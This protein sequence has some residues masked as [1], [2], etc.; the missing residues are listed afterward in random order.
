MRPRRARRSGT[1]DRYVIGSFLLPFVVSLLFF[2]LLIEMADLFVNLVQ[3]IQNEVAVADVVRSVVLYAPRCVSWAL[4]I[5]VLFSV[6]YALGTLYAANELIVVFASGLSLRSFVMPFVVLSLVLSGAYFAF[7]D[8]VVIPSV[9]AK[10]ELVRT[11]LKTGTVAGASDVTILGEGRRLLW[12]VRYYDQ[13]N[14]TMTGVTVVERDADGAFASRLNA[15]S[16]AWVDGT[17]RFTGVRRFFWKEGYLTDESYGT[18]DSPDYAESPDSFRGGGRPVEEMRLEDARVHIAFLERAGLPS[19]GPKAE[20]LRR[21]AFALTPLMVTLLSAGLVGRFR[22]NV[23]LMSL[24]VSLVGA[25]LYYVAQMISMLL[26][27]NE[28]VMPAAGAFAPLA[29]FALIT[30]ALIRSRKA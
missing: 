24:L 11:M 25:T 12:S 19:A 21:F 20:Y 16:A 1:L 3:Y 23:L 13:V 29:V 6:S 28:T 18:W 17:W 15:Q 4:P 22:K 7:D 8:M 2:V 5:A 14:A 10:K 26:A 9:Y 27:K 30:L